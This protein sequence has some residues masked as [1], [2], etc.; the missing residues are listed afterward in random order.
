MHLALICKDRRVELS[1][2]TRT[3]SLNA[4]QIKYSPYKPQFTHS[5]LLLLKYTLTTHSGAKLILFVFHIAS[6]AVFHIITRVMG[7][8]LSIISMFDC[9]MRPIYCFPQKVAT[10]FM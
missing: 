6:Q 8:K 3:V 10:D 4:E 5:S 7:T 9:M 1:S 2:C